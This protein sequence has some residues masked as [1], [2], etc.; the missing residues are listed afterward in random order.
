MID[1]CYCGNEKVFNGVLL[2]ALSIAKTTSEPLNIFLLTADISYLKP[3]YV[4]IDEK[5]RDFIEKTIQKYNPESKVILVD[6]TKE[7]K[8]TF[9]EGKNMNSMYTPYAFLRLLMDETPGLP[10]RIL[11]LDV[12]TV[13]L[14]DVSPLFHYDLGDKAAAV[15][16]DAMREKNYFNS[17]V[18]LFDLAKIKKEG[19]FKKTRAYLIGH[20][21]MMPDQDAFNKIFKNN[22]IMISRIYNEQRLTK[23][24]TVIRHYCQSIR[25]LPYFHIIKVK[26]WER[27]RFASAYKRDNKR[28]IF[29]EFDALLLE[30]NK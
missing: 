11:Y 21:L 20:K 8:D 22:Y 29:A 26:P 30:L 2:S 27:K 28:D 9:S 23:H 4:K 15:V 1:I 25:V 19:L 17:G 14:K 12:D 10:D 24:D 5:S 18:I 13:A 16:H 3:V 7:F 6:A